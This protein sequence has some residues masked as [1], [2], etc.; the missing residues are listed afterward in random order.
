MILAMADDA[1]EVVGPVAG[2]V[3]GDDAV[4]VGDAAG[5]EPDLGSGEECGC[6]RAL[7]VVEW[8]VSGLWCGVEGRSCRPS[9]PW[10]RHRLTHFDAHAREIP[11]SAPT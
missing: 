4:N 8:F 10:R 1:G 7:L 9:S 5:G 2:A 11:I 6:G 3:V